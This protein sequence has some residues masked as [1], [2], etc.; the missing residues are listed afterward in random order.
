[1][2][3]NHNYSSL[4]YDKKSGSNIVVNPVIWNKIQKSVPVGYIIPDFKITD[5][6]AAHIC[7]GK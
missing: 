6:I 5:V 7:Y 3:T 4:F 1:M 2:D